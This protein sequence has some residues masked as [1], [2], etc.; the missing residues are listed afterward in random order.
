MSEPDAHHNP[1]LRRSQD[2][3]SKHRRRVPSCLF[4]P[5]SAN[6]L[7]KKNR[8]INSDYSPTP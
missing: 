7:Q 4:P 6:T 2:E 1:S 3:A 8:K 5:F